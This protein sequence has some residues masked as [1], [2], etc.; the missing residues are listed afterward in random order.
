MCPWYPHPREAVVMMFT[1][2][3]K[4]G[5]GEVRVMEKVS[6]EEG[7]ALFNVAVSQGAT[8]VDL[9][10]DTRGYSPRVLHPAATW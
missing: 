6:E 3:R 4:D 9:H 10:D 5:N 2:T 1:V 7:H 8:Y